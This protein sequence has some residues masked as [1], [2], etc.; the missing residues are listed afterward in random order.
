MF[1]MWG[2]IEWQQGARSIQRACCSLI[3][4]ADP[5]PAARA[6]PSIGRAVVPEMPCS[7]APPLFRR[8]PVHRTRTF[9]CTCSCCGSSGTRWGVRHTTFQKTHRRRPITSS[10]TQ[11]RRETRQSHIG[12]RFE[13][14]FFTTQQ[15]M[16]WP[17]YRR[18]GASAQIG[19][20]KR[21]EAPGHGVCRISLPARRRVNHLPLMIALIS[22]P[23]TH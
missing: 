5:R 9:R 16:L 21:R 15:K 13:W 17:F 11:E 6:Q 20:H 8:N 12:S 2:S 18:E 22:E 10:P 14:P 4:P 7:G 23:W 19:P 1:F 3:K